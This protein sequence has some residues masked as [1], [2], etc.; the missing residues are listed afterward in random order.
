MGTR[1]LKSNILQPSTDKKKLQARY[2]A[3]EELT[4]KEHSFHEIRDGLLI[5]C[6]VSVT[7]A[8]AW[9]AL[10]GFVDTDRVLG[11]VRNS[12]WN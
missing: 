8:D 5:V 6:W 3:V 12:E 10:K 9:S 7:D 1:V 4:S 11:Q 2:D